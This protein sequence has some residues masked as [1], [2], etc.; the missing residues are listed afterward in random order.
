MN[1]GSLRLSYAR[2]TVLLA[3]I[4]AAQSVP[5]AGLWGP[6]GRSVQYRPWQVVATGGSRSRMALGP[7]EFGAR[8]VIVSNYY[9]FLRLFCGSFGRE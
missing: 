8:V 3:V 6:P 5:N 1:E 7:P 2:V 4:N 9:C